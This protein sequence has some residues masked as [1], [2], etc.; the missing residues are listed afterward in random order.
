[1]REMAGLLELIGGVDQGL[2][3][4]ASYVEAGAANVFAFDKSGGD[5]ELRSTDRRDIAAGTA[6]D[7]EQGGR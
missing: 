6:A 3:R 1:M 4:N 5:P 7:D 2:R